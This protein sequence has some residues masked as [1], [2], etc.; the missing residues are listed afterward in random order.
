M[1]AWLVAIVLF[2]P[3]IKVGIA[4]MALLIP[5]MLFMLIGGVVTDSF[6]GKRVAMI[7]QALAVLPIAAL[8]IVIFTDSLTFEIMLVYAVSIGILQA[9]VTPARDSLLN[10]VAFGRIQRTVIKAT[11]MQFVAQMLGF[12]LAATADT[13]GGVFVITT[14][15]IIVGFGVLALSQ[16]PNTQSSA[17]LKSG[18]FLAV[19]KTSILEGAQTVWDN[20]AMRSV[21]GQNI[22]MGICFMGSYIVTIPLLIRE[23][24]EGTSFDLSI[25]SLFNSSGLVLTIVL[26]LLFSRG[27]RRQG[28]ALL[29][30]H[31]V[32]AF[33]LGIGG[34]GISY[35]A[36]CALV[37]LWGAC[38]GVAMS[39]SRTIMQE[40]APE[41]QRGRVMAF[42]SF[43]FMGSG[44]IGAMLWG[45]SA[46]FFGPETTLLVANISMFCIVL[47][48][49][50]N[51]RLWRMKS[52]FALD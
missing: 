51:S 48:I 30:A 17:S 50:L 26:L 1:F 39:M 37:F 38:G 43:S 18:S 11:L 5:A 9:F 34:L 15:A 40:Q 31:G 27:I 33:V 25:L 6:G 44:P 29:I 20:R 23:R 13:L 41:S 14:Q 24:Y 49:S 2:E 22:A 52:T 32:G 3:P 19:M 8:A 42:F 28:R 47:M 12:T 46:Q 4:Q 10:Y 21:V 36:F 7:S 16:L 35:W 45:T